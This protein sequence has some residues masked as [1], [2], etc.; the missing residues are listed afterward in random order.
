L[1]G[2]AL[3]A[4]AAGLPLKV[5]WMYGRMRPFAIQLADRSEAS[6]LSFCLND[7]CDAL[8]A[9]AVLPR[10]ELAAIQPAVLDFLNGPTFRNWAEIALGL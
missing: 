2:G 3:Y 5:A 9:T 1:F 8:V 4:Q 7:H 10:G 6:M